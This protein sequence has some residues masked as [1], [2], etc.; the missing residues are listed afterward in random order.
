ME[1][2]SYDDLKNMIA[3]DTTGRCL[4]TSNRGHNCIFVLLD[5]NTGHLCCHAMKSRKSTEMVDACRTCYRR[6]TKAGFT[7]QLVR[8]DNEVSKELITAVKGDK[9]LGS[10]GMDHQL[11]PPDNH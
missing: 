5:V 11:V 8:L 10:E 6:L 7:A 2:C 4:I 3:I 9:T 1:A